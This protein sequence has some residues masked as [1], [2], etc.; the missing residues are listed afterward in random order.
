MQTSQ[1]IEQTLGNEQQTVNKEDQKGK[2]EQKINH[3]QALIDAILLHDE[4]T[5]QTLI[6]TPQFNFRYVDAIGNNLLFYATQEGNISLVKKLLTHK[7]DTNFRNQHGTTVLHQAA[8]MGR[9]DLVELF[10]N[11]HADIEAVHQLPDKEKQR[12]LECAIENGHFEV[13]KRLVDAGTELKKGIGNLNPFEWARKCGQIIILRYFDNL[14]LSAAEKKVMIEED[15][16]LRYLWGEFVYDPRDS[17]PNHAKKMFTNTNLFD[18]SAERG[19]KMFNNVNMFNVALE[20]GHVGIANMLFRTNE[21]WDFTEYNLDT[22]DGREKSETQ[23][24]EY[25]EALFDTFIKCICRNH[26]N[27]VKWILKRYPEFLNKI[28]GGQGERITPITVAASYENIEIVKFLLQQNADIAII[29]E[30][31]TVFTYMATF[32]LNSLKNRREILQ[33]MLDTNPT[34]YQF[35]SNLKNSAQDDHDF[36]N[37]LLAA[38]EHLNSDPNIIKFLAAVVELFYFNKTNDIFL[39]DKNFLK[40]IIASVVQHAAEAILKGLLEKYKEKPENKEIRERILRIKDHKILHRMIENKLDFMLNRAPIHHLLPHLSF[41]LSCKAQDYRR[42]GLPNTRLSSPLLCKINSFLGIEHSNIFG[43]GCSDEMCRKYM[44]FCP[45]LLL[46]S[47]GQDFIQGFFTIFKALYNRRAIFVQRKYQEKFKSSTVAL[48]LLQNSD[49][50]QNG[51]EMQR[52]REQQSYDPSKRKQEIPRA[53]GFGT[54][55]WVFGGNRDSKTH[56]ETN[57][58]TDTRSLALIP[59]ERSPAERFFSAV[60]CDDEA[61]ISAAF[62]MLAEQ[63]PKDTLKKAVLHLFNK[64][65]ARDFDPEALLRVMLMPEQSKEQPKKQS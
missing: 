35:I 4:A 37:D 31:N 2:Q 39:E 11:N 22:K 19:K 27:S 43:L 29:N 44:N 51:A 52:H 12:P 55:S 6:D 32:G 13:V 7:F 40:N 28:S 54:L 53:F 24:R 3:E 9:M 1:S 17:R 41:A 10:L 57:A 30:R 18:A 20:Y 25:L 58:T 15:H 62:E 65:C 64:T 42:V 34:A 56:A 45:P 36:I 5:I 8:S 47:F 61:G 50:L 46:K 63:Y 26:L 60:E 49:Q 59:R 33:L 21:H 23:E 14:K 16:Y 48:Q 38:R